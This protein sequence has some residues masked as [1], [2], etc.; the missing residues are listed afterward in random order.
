M[1]P[2]RCPRLEI[3]EDAGV[4]DLPAFAEFFAVIAEND[5]DR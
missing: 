5:D 1:Q 3:I 2:E 4:C